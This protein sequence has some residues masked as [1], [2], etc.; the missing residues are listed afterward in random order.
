MNRWLVFAKRTELSGICINDISC[1]MLY[2]D[3]RIKDMTFITYDKE[4]TDGVDI[5]MLTGPQM[6]MRM[7]KAKAGIMPTYSGGVIS[8]TQ[9]KDEWKTA[10]EAEYPD[11][12]VV[13]A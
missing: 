13:P 2:S 12:F 11:M 8:Y 6:E 3:A 10:V 9:T 4:S 7:M 1:G 5:S